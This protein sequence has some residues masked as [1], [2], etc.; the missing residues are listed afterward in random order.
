MSELGWS[1]YE[2]VMMAL[3]LWREARGETI[4]AQE[5]VTWT[6]RNRCRKGWWNPSGTLIGAVVHPFQ[7][8]SMTDPGDRQTCRFPG[9]AQ[10]DGGWIPDQA[11]M[12]C[13][14]VID[15]V[16]MLPET[17]DPTGGSDSY[18]DDSIDPPA[19]ATPEK[20]RGKIGRISFF[21]VLP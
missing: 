20:A 16:T 8:S 21:K 15:Q 10:K 2:R 9:Y 3:C 4:E 12:Q 5:W 7:Y 11:M 14:W 19:W 1:D 6:I 18:Y 17:M 13:L